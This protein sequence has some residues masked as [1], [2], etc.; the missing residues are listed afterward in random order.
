[1]SP[2]STSSGDVGFSFVAVA[3]PQENLLAGTLDF[4]QG[5]LGETVDLLE[6]RAAAGVELVLDLVP[7]IEGGGADLPRVGDLDTH[8]PLGAVPGIGEGLSVRPGLAGF[9]AVTV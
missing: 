7:G 6:A 3:A 1:M 9:P 5:R 4:Y 8:E 2:R